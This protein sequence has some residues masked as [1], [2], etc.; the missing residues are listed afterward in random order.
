MTFKGK[1]PWNKGLVGIYKHSDASKKKIGESNSR[2]I[3]SEETRK[4][5]SIIY[6]GKQSWNKGNKGYL[7]GN[8]HWNYIDGRS[9]SKIHKGNLFR[10][11]RIENSARMRVLQM[12]RNTMKVGSHTLK[13]WEILKKEFNYM[14][15]CCKRHEP[16]ITLTE[17][18]IIPLSK[19]GSNNIENIQPLC[20][21]C[22]STKHTRTIN[23]I[24]LNN[25]KVLQ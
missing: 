9:K 15:L 5:F 20:R 18:H 16:E 1:I 19:G 4:K 25:Q 10:K 13:E 22:N 8:K 24:N 14:C 2:R 7:S 21:S 12:K 17:D 3:I 11:W 23:F 6:K